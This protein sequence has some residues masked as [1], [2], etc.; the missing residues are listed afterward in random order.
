MFGLIFTAA[1]LTVSQPPIPD[2][3]GSADTRKPKLIAKGEG[4]FVHALPPLGN[5]APLTREAF[6]N[7]GGLTRTN[8]DGPVIL[9]TALATGEMKTLAA[10]WLS[11]QLGPPMGVDR[12][13]YQR[14]AIA[15]VAADNQRLY[16][17]QWQT[18]REETVGVPGEE[19]G[20]LNVKYRLLVFRPAKGEL[21]YTLEL[22]EGDFPKKLPQQTADRGP[23]QL[24]D[25]GVACFGVT[26]TFEGTRLVKQRYEKK[27]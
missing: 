2:K 11:A 21:V 9:H 26:F 27:P 15:G 13:Y 19:V 22:K 20:R 17:L 12:I 6:N 10:G 4:Y 24:H 18:N 7:W 25:D 14:T 3:W 23:L 5:P 8:V 16:V 1:A